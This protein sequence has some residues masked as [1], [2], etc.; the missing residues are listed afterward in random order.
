V[1]QT[2]VTARAVIRNTVSEDYAMRFPRT[3]R[4]SARYSKWG[5]T[6]CPNFNGGDDEQ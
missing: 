3:S 5:L 1:G 6:L 2:V 4:D